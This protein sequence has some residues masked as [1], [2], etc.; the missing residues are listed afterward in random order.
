MID[1]DA[2]GRLTKW[3]VWSVDHLPMTNGYIDSGKDDVPDTAKSGAWY[4]EHGT[5]L[6]HVFWAILWVP[7]LGAAFAG[8]MF[9]M[10]IMMHVEAHYEFVE[11]HPF[12]N[13]VI[14]VASYFIP[15][16]FLLGVALLVG[17]IILAL[18]GGS[19]TGFFSLLWQYL[20]GIKQRICPLVHFDG[21]HMQPAE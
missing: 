2:T 8:F 16:A 17:I 6:C 21:A 12:A 13:P 10:V 18:M 20:K 11:K 14:Q 4:V 19:K 15:E 1:L 7:L 9:S 3:F 5:T